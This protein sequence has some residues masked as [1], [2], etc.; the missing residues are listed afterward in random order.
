MFNLSSKQSQEC[1]DLFLHLGKIDS[2][3]GKEAVMVREVLGFLEALGVEAEKD[4]HNNV[5]SLNKT[6]LESCF[7]CA[8]L[9]TVES[10]KNKAPHLE[11]GV[12]HSNGK[13]ILGADN[14]V[15]ICA[16]LMALK[17]CIKELHI[18]P[19]VEVLFT[20]GEE[21]G[22]TGIKAFDLKNLQSNFGLVLD[23]FL[24]VG[25][26]V[27]QAPGK[28]LFELEIKGN[29]AQ[30]AQIFAQIWEDWNKSEFIDIR[31]ESRKETKTQL[32]V[33]GSFK[34]FSDSETSL[35]CVERGFKKFKGTT[36]SLSLGLVR[37]PYKHNEK[38]DFLKVI[39]ESFTQIG[40][41]PFL[42]ASRGVSDA[43][44]LNQRGKKAFLL[45]TNVKKAHTVNETLALKDLEN[46]I[47]F[48]VTFLRK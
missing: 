16:I 27:S 23:S 41:E 30:T 47:A 40:L 19:K 34:I 46:L 7:L 6:G 37:E 48:L 24:P 35:K 1:I 45:G 33:M 29:R 5:W 3:S 39:F 26:V 12:F 2:P 4:R 20:A 9:D 32:K 43:N 31:E 13:T 25:G 14:L 15:G 42:K 38:D 17:I 21:V 11:D 18:T 10:A 44:D 36:D 8:H 28:C 22:G